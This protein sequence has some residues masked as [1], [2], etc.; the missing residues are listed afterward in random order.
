MKMSPPLTVSS[1][2]GGR[3]STRL[4]LRLTE[5]N[6]LTFTSSQYCAHSGWLRGHHIPD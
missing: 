5:L 3:R 6:T 1:L 4:S 2:M